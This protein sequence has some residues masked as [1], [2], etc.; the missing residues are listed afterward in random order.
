MSILVASKISRNKLLQTGT[1]TLQTGN[2]YV[3]IL[4]KTHI[5]LD[6]INRIKN[7]WLGAIF[8]STG[9]S[10]TKR[11][12]VLLYLGIEGVIEI[13]TD[14]KLRFL[15]FKVT[16]SNDRVLGVYAPSGHDTKE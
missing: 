8:L 11:L 3:V 7:N 5:N 16:P 1:S 4:T 14:S 2:K 10:H 9:E 15:S 13:E 12:L 6:Q